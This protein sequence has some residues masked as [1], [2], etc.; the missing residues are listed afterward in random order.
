MLTVSFTGLISF[1]NRGVEG[2]ERRCNICLVRKDLDKDFYRD[3]TR[4]HGKA[5]ICKPCTRKKR[6]RYIDRSKAASNRQRCSAGQ[7]RKAVE[8]LGGICVCCHESCL[9]YLQIDHVENDGK[10]HRELL[11]HGPQAL[12]RWVLKHPGT[13][14]VQLLCANCHV[15]KTKYKT[16]CKDRHRCDLNTTDRLNHLNTLSSAEEKPHGDTA[17]R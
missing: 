4:S 1:C 8:Q 9:D 15:Y 16:L 2:L 5:A 10:L 6:I 17:A 3:R 7:R 12:Y 11:I 13:V 14:R